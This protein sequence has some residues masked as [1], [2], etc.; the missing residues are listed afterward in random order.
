M[1]TVTPR[2]QL[3][4]PKPRIFRI[5]NELSIINRMG[6]PGKG[7]DFVARQIA[8]RKNRHSSTIIGVNI[9]KNKD[10]PNEEAVGDYVY[11]L[12]K[13]SSIAD[14][15]A[16]NVSSPN[17]VGTNFQNVDIPRM[18]SV[19]TVNQR[20]ENAKE[21]TVMHLYKIKKGKKYYPANKKTFLKI[22]KDKKDILEKYFDENKFNFKNPDD[23]ITISN[24]CNTL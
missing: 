21:L 11:L 16:I 18:G 9:G 15:I 7:A 17:T 10:T 14:Y 6:F 12:E 20:K 23:L 1:G 19:Y 3:G 24:Y 8:I 13:F 2:A 22:Y 4:N 5:P